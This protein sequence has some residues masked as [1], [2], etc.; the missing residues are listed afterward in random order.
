MAANGLG[1]TGGDFSELNG[2]ERSKVLASLGLLGKT[3]LG[4]TSET[5]GNDADEL[6]E[7][8]VGVE[9]GP[10]AL[11]VDIALFTEPIGALETS[12]FSMSSP[13]SFDVPCDAGVVKGTV[14][15][16]GAA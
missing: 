2:V 9:G 7:C 5:E 11:N 13:E 1:F 8:F 3:S 6:R 10:F 14:L 16:A 15:A 12:G 4:L